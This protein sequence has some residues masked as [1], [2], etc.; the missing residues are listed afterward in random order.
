MNVLF[1]NLCRKDSFTNVI[2]DI[3]RDEEIDL[4]AFAEFPKGK[5][6]FF[7]SELRAVDKSFTYLE[8]IADNRRIDVFYK[9]GIVDIINSFGGERIIVDRIH[10][11][12]N[13]QDY[14]IVFCHLRDARNVSKEQLAGF[15]REIVKEILDF[16]KEKD[17]HHLI[18]CGDFNMNPYDN[19]MIEHDSF[20]AMQTAALANKC[21]RNV[22]GK[23]YLLFYNPMWGLFGDLHGQ[24]VPG[25]YYYAPSIPIQPYWHILD[26]VIMRPEVINVFDK[27]QLKIVTKGPSYNLLNANNN[28]CHKY[29]DHLPIKFTLNI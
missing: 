20:N 6:L 17:N 11:S 1:W 13:G 5:E 19:A 4:V 21:N 14:Y 28:I 27:K 12:A 15:A 26:Q 25:T 23:P 9:S 24:D 29:S 16:E 10:S 8:P 2:A 3:I 7:E 18:V 22:Y